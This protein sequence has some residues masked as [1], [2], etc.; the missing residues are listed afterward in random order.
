MFN[1]I[2]NYFTADRKVID[3]ARGLLAEIRAEQDA[4]DDLVARLE[5]KALVMKLERLGARK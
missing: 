5:A 3:E 2:K 4:A 1:K